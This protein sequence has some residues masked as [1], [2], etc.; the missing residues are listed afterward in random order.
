MKP[1]RDLPWRRRQ[2]VAGQNK[3]LWSRV[4]ASWPIW[5]TIGVVVSFVLTQGVESLA[6]LR[7]LPSELD[8]TFA[9]FQSWYYDD[10]AWTGSWSSRVEGYIDDLHQSAVPLKLVLNVSRGAVHGE[11]L[12]K[13]VCRK[14]NPLL[15]PVLLQGQ[16]RGGDV[17]ADAFVYMGGQRNYL[18]NC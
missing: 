6:N 10:A 17:E 2:N 7:K 14:L 15:L 8:E 16:V 5:A 4:K 1:K 11:M 18:V 13:E 12:N 3:G 9:G